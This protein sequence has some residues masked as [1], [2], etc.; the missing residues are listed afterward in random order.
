MGRT[1]MIVYWLFMLIMDLL[2]PL[3]MI[4][5][6]ER[7]KKKAPN[8]NF[9]Y[10]YRTSMSMK[11]KDTWEFAHKHCGKLWFLLGLVLAPISAIPLLFVLEKDMVTLAAVGA[12][13]CIVQFVIL[14]V[15][16]IPTEVALKK[17]YDRNGNPKV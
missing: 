9:I 10:G 7:F 14:L 8:V 17:H 15:S 5:L 11:N 12:S 16:I 3:G 6:G 1:I 4:I 13:V 2:I